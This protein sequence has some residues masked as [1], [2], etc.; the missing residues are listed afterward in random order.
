MSQLS[1][2]PWEVGR[3]SQGHL[4]EYSLPGLEPGDSFMVVIESNGLVFNRV[5]FLDSIHESMNEDNV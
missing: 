3:K 4:T 1:N 5:H 2:L